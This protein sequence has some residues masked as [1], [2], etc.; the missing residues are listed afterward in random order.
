MSGSAVRSYKQRLDVFI[1]DREREAGAPLEGRL[2]RLGP[3]RDLF[4]NR[5]WPLFLLLLLLHHT[6]GVL[7]GLAQFG[8][9]LDGEAVT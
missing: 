1:A 2:Q 5:R 7:F 8:V 3:D 4:S 6:Q 9:A